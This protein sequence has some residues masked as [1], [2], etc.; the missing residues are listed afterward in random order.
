MDLGLRRKTAIITGGSKGVGYG[1]AERLAAEGCDLVLVARSK[2]ELAEARTRLTKQHDVDVKVHAADLSIEPE[3]IALAEAF[4]DVDI[5]INNAGAIR[6]GALDEVDNELWRQYWELKIF[7][8]INLSR[9][10]FVRMKQRRQGVILNIIGVAGERLDSGYIAGSTGNASLMAFTRA[11]G[12]TSTAFNVRVLGINPGPVLTDK[13]E[14]RLRRQAGAAGDAEKWRELMKAMPFGRAALPQELGNVAA[15]LV[16][17]CASY[18]SGT[19]VTVDGG[20]TQR[21]TI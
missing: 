10:Y 2:D 1:I 8:Y 4:P 11:L 19:V 6:H 14:I 5:L 13:L 15:F 18:V 17:D 12:S 9:A 21:W 20:W 7:G 16:S 3:R